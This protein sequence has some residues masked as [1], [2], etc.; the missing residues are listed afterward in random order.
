MRRS[1]PLVLCLAGL[2][3]C[4]SPPKPPNVDEAQRRPV[5]MAAAVDLQRCRSDLQNTRILATENAHAAEAASAVAARL[6]AQRQTPVV[7]PAP[8]PAPRNA[9]HTVLFAFGSAT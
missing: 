9:I 6:T 2:G 7:Q 4:S 3:S 8:A 5:N 1:M